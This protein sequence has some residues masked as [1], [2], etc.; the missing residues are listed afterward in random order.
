[1]S[2]LK[3]YQDQEKDRQEVA[4]E[5]QK[6]YLSVNLPGDRSMEVDTEGVRKRIEAMKEE[7]AKPNHEVKK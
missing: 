3:E 6:F 4:S 2:T 5:T 1:M 7:K